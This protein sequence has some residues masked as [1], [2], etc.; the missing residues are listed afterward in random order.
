MY[1]TDFLVTPP[2]HYFVL[3]FLNLSALCS[4]EEAIQARFPS[5]HE[6][7][8]DAVISYMFNI[9]MEQHLICC[10][11]SGESRNVGFEPFSEERKLNSSDPCGSGALW[12]FSCCTDSC[13]LFANPGERVGSAF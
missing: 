2:D 13:Y 5:R 9:K 3:V 4:Q 12:P 1:F 7:H 6:L 10:I 8:W 11:L